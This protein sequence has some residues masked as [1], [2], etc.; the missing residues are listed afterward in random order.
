MKIK[1]VIITVIL[2]ILFILYWYVSNSSYN[3][4]PK[5]VKEHSDLIT[6]MNNTAFGYISIMSYCTIY[7]I[8]FILSLNNFFL[9]ENS[10]NIIRENS[11]KQLYIKRIK[12]INIMSWIICS[13]HTIT[14]L[15]LIIEF[16]GLDYI[17]ERNFIFYSIL[18]MIGIVMFY[19][20]VGFVFYI[21][22]DLTKKFSSA[23]LITSILFAGLFFYQKISKYNFWSPIKDIV[24]LGQ[25]LDN[26]ILIKQVIIIYIRQIL[27]MF[28]VGYIG[29]NIMNGR[30]FYQNEK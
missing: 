14:N 28:L 25:L 24:I 1:R 18:H 17:I 4:M 5:V 13:I 11:R 19:I 6:L 2:S 12:K 29:Y 26:T 21:L 7:L 9:S 30:D 16:F 8:P 20:M 22:D 3:E 15:I 27:I 10:I 23:T